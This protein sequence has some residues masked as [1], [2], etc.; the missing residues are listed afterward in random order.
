V[1]NDVG[2]GKF[3]VFWV[4]VV[5]WVVGGGWVWGVG[6]L[7]HKVNLPQTKKTLQAFTLTKF[8][9]KINL[10]TYLFDPLFIRLTPITI[11]NN[12]PKIITSP[13]YLKISIISTY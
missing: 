6:G 13:I 11:Y 7:I 1:S 8:L 4:A 10:F 12:A 2:R 9:I 5:W 3:G